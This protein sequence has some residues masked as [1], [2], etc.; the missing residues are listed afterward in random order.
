MFVFVFFLQLLLN[1][2]PLQRLQ[3]NLY[4]MFT[5]RPRLLMKSHGQA[6]KRYIWNS[7][8]NMLYDP[9]YC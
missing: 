8:I 1:I 9:G 5:V 3:P 7:N 2:C 4:Y 6:G